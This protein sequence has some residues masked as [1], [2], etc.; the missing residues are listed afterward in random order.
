MNNN[1]LVILLALIAV[2]AIGVVGYYYGQTTASVTPVTT[3]VEYDGE[4]SD[5]GLPNE[6]G[7]TDLQVETAYAESNDAGS[8]TLNITTDMNAS[9]NAI[10]GQTWYLATRFDINGPVEELSI[11]GTMDSTASTTCETKR[12]Y[13]LKDE[14]GVTMDV[15]NAIATCEVD[16]DLDDFECETG[17][18][19]KGDYILVI[20]MKAVSVSGSIDGNDLYSVEL[21]LDTEGDVDELTLD[22]EA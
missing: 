1:T 12:V 13:L 19:E 3:V 8:I 22:I 4:F 9:E 2:V 14:E 10:N 20:E 15:D 18:L 17:P 7:G 16:S 21:E 11:D 6:V 5:A